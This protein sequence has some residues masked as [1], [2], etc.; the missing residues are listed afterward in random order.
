MTVAELELPHTYM[1]FTLGGKIFSFEA[2]LLWEASDSAVFT[3]VPKTGGSLI[4]VTQMH[5]KIVPVLDLAN[6]LGLGAITSPRGFIA[7][8]LP[9]PVEFLAGFTVDSVV[10]FAKIPPEDI[11]W[12]DGDSAVP[13]FPYL[14]GWVEEGNRFPLLDMERIFRDQA[15]GGPGSDEVNPE[16]PQGEKYV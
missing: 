10:G 5:G 15:S 4:G 7:V 6:L 11:H 2:R 3:E 12:L 9:G 14:K 13:M 16:E 1:V 8:S